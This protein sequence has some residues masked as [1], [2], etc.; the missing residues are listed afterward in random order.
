[1]ALTARDLQA[2]D[3]A[4]RSAGRAT[5]PDTTYA[6]AAVNVELG[7]VETTETLVTA[8]TGANDVPNLSCSFVVRE[9]PV[10]VELDLAVVLT[11]ST[12]CTVL[13]ELYDVTAGKV[14]AQKGESITATE[15]FLQRGFRLKRRRQWPAGPRTIKARVSTDAGVVTLY[16]QPVTNGLEGP[17]SLQVV[18]V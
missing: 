9:R 1:M 12:A 5:T 15:G 13:V 2:M 11:V 18:E 17:S 6:P 10:V 7:Y 14:I 8:G 3:E 4:R 16:N